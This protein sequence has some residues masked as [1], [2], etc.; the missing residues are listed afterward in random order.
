M[1][2]AKVIAG[3]C[4][5][6]QSVLFFILFLAYWNRSRSLAR[7]LAVFSAVGGIGGAWLVVSQLKE[8]KRSDVMDEELDEFDDAFSYD[9]EDAFDDISCSFGGEVAE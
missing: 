6:G 4:L 9:G 2:K 8:K 1:K 5:I 7:T 3:M